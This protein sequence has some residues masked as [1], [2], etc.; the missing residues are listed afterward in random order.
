MSPGQKA[1]L[2]HFCPPVFREV[3]SRIRRTCIRFTGPYGSWAEA[4]SRSTGY[5]SEE[6][7]E[8]VKAAALKVRSGQA[9]YE[10]DGVVFSR[11][12]YSFPLLATL[13]RASL[14]ADGRLNVMDFGG[15][16][17]SSYYQNR[18]FLAELKS[19]R[20]S[21]VEQPGVVECGRAGFQDE[22]LRFYA[23]TDECLSLERPNV[24][25]FSSVLQYLEQ[26]FKL[27][28]TIAEMKIPHVII[29][30]T[31]FLVR[32]GSR[33]L[34]AVQ[35]VPASIYPASYPVWLFAQESISRALASSYQCLAEFQ[36]SEAPIGF[37]SLRSNLR[38]LIY[39]LRP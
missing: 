38:G 37:G 10:R 1:I 6:I 9:A 23:S 4:Q 19:F 29:D 18:N 8:R 3:R 5:G 16:L 24:A 11:G 27:L 28:E 32:P 17:G 33:D 12:E 35:H 15:S 36:A 26:P 14:A 22:Q 39:D 7:L 34:V 31:P 21:V 20:W 25:L 30:R 2:L 13:L